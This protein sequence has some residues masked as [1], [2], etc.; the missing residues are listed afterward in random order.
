MSR[1]WRNKSQAPKGTKVPDGS[2]Y[3]LYDLDGK[4]YYFNNN[5]TTIILV[6]RPYFPFASKNPLMLWKRRYFY[7]GKDN[8][9]KTKEIRRYIKR[10]R[11]QYCGK[12]EKSYR[13]DH[14]KKYRKKCKQM[15]K[16]GRWD[17]IPRFR[18]TS[19]WLTW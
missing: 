15:V 8:K 10:F 18:K 14:Y 4:V 16:K 12:E 19:G 17:E 11:R 7:S 6:R 1:T 3:F 9:R 13:K 5:T 2:E